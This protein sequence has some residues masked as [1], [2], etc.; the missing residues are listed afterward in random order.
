M[1]AIG[2]H[3]LARLDGSSE[4]PTL[5]ADETSRLSV[6]RLQLTDFRSFER[7]RLELDPRPVVLSG[8]NGAGK[9]N[10]LESLSFLAP[11]RGLRRARLIE[12]ARRQPAHDGNG[13]GEAAPCWT[14]AVRLITSSGKVEVGTGCQAMSPADKGERRV[15][16]I[17]GRPVKSH[18]ALAEILGTYW[19]TPRMDRLLVDG[20]SARRRFIDRLVI[21]F[22]PAHGERLGAYKLALRERSLLLRHG[23]Q[24]SNPDWLAALE[25]RMAANGI[26]LAAAR[27]E[28]VCRLAAA[29]ASGSGPFPGASIEVRGELE[30][31]LAE[32][33]ALAA[34]EH[35]RQ[36]LAAARKRDAETGGAGS[37]PHRS[38]IKVRQLKSG[39]P[40]ELCSTGE[41]KA[42]LIAIVLASA[43]ILAA[44]RGSAPLLLLDEA[45]AHL[46]K[47][48]CEALFDEILAMD[49]Q[50]W[51]TG[52][53]A[54][55]FAPLRGK[56]Q[57]FT[58]E[59]ATA[60]PEG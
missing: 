59:N 38:D 13:G 4:A 56:A 53:D 23:W 21:G 31:W 45:A 19:L 60:R 43:R 17:D 16:H 8:P 42:L 7:L 35:F 37:G 39:Q 24:G 10:I 33:P 32:K 36:V 18:A 27:C 50:A 12:A 57:F 49:A 1:V 48:R 29:L 30:S 20:A 9:T 14:V 54:A 28:T 51:L 22:D 15:V 11:G 3:G 26:A 52:T 46:D 2:F 47:T 6:T 25:H 58:V 55:L 44:E 40:A 5:M 41:Q 34:E